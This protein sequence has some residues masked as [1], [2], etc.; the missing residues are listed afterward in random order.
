MDEQLKALLECLNALKSG[1]D[2]FKERLLKCQ[3]LKNTLEEKINKMEIKIEKVKEQVDERMKE[4]SQQVE[5][6]EKKLPT[7]R[8]TK[9]SFCLLL[10]YLY[11]PHQSTEKDQKMKILTP[12]QEDPVQRTN[13]KYSWRVEKKF[14]VIGP[15]VHLVTMPPPSE[16]DPW[17]DKSIR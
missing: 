7:C 10:Q 15:E 6:L 17:S 1:Q 4:M 5:D 12:L 14:G 8:K 11:L 3:D 9:T 2:E 13:S 16:S